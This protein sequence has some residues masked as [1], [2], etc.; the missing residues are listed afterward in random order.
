MFA[1]I[2][3]G[4]NE[5][6][7]ARVYKSFKLHRTA[8]IFMTMSMGTVKPLLQG[9]SPSLT[10]QLAS[11]SFMSNCFFCSSVPSLQMVLK[12]SQVCFVLHPLVSPSLPL[13]CVPVIL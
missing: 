5:D 12:S 2:Y 9:V 3:A 6:R 13:V 4:E 10:Q 7:S 8:N 11:H 1:L